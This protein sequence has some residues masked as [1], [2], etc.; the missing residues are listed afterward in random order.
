MRK[1]KC[2]NEIAS[3]RNNIVGYTLIPKSDRTLEALHLSEHELF[4]QIHR[5]AFKGESEDVQKLLLGFPEFKRKDLKSM[6]IKS[7]R[8]LGKTLTL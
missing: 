7:V 8:T 5:H 1:Y 4:Q 3:K 2:R 6:L